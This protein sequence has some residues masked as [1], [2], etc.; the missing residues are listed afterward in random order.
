MK[1]ILKSVININKL[2]FNLPGKFINCHLQ[3]HLRNLIVIT[4]LYY[5]SRYN[6]IYFFKC[7]NSDMQSSKTE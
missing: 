2:F 4:I 5:N 3:Q 7:I 1:L 6:I